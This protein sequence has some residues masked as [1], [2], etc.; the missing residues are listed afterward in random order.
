[1][2]K[3]SIVLLLLLTACSTSMPSQT[4]PLTFEG[5]DY[6]FNVAE[7]K[8]VDDYR[9]TRQPPHVEHLF[10]L[11]PAGA[12]HQWAGEKL[13]AGGTS[14]S[15]AVVITEASVL[16]KD[17]PKTK[18]G[19]TGMLT[20]EQ[21]EQYDGTLSVEMKLYVPDRALPIAQT[22]ASVRQSHTLREDAGVFHR[23]ALYKQMTTDLM[24]MLQQE[25]DRNIR[26]YF[27]NY[28]L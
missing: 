17:L 26:Q 24:Q 15:L 23:E 18:H 13:S 5:P 28:M 22:R 6:R 4:P 27:S 1:M 7:I 19:I 12:I 25:L 21:T 8:V 2:K 9:P 14:G 3:F 11:S 20:K 10:E 16:R